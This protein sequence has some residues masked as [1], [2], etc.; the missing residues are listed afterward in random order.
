MVNHINLELEISELINSNTKIKKLLKEIEK[1]IPMIITHDI[2]L[3]DL[4]LSEGTLINGAINAINSL[5]MD[6]N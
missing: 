1:S 4:N 5:S 2:R 3:N 6:M